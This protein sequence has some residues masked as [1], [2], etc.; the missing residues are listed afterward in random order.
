MP[1]RQLGGEIPAGEVDVL[2]RGRGFRWP[3]K[4][5][6]SCSSQPDRAR[7]VRHKWRGVW[8]LKRD[9]PARTASARTT[10]DHV[11]RVIGRARLRRDSE[12]KSSPRAALSPRRWARYALQQDPRRRRVGH[13]PRPP[14]LRGL[15]ADAQRAIRGVQIVRAQ[16]AQLLPPQPGVVGQREHQAGPQRLAPRDREQL[17]HSA[18]DGI[19]GSLVKRGIRPRSRWPPKPRP[20]VYRP[21]P[22]GLVSRRPSSIR[23]S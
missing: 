9:T 21:R 3:A 8:V 6:I 4:L 5:A 19:Q 12:R 22:T 10:L 1:L 20:G 18:S 2:Q 16:A 13:H 14:T 7:S 15:G 23:W 11:Q 17:R